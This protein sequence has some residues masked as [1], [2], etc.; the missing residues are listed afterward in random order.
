MKTLSKLGLAFC[1]C[2]LSLPALAQFD[3]SFVFDDSMFDDSSLFETADSQ[4]GHF[5]FRLSHQS[6]AHINRHTRAAVGGGTETRAR[7]LEN[8]RSALNI[9][10]QNPFREGWLLQASG[11]LRGY[12]PGDYE[13][14]NPT[15]EDWEWRLNE[16]FVQRSG[17]RNSLA[18]GRQ[19]IVW[20]E[21]IGNSVLDVINTTEYRDLTIIDIEDARLNQWLLVW[22]HFSDHGTWSS[23][24]NLY[25]E[26]DPLPVDNSPLFPGSPLRLPHYHRDKPLFELGTRWSRSFTGSDV[27]VMAARLYENGLRFTPP[28]DGSN[29]AI[30]HIN[31]Y[32]LLGL[33]ANRAIDR[34]L[35]TLDMSYSQGVLVDSLTNAFP[36]LNKGDLLGISAGFEYGISATRLISVG[37]RFE[38]LQNIERGAAERIN[39]LRL[40]TRGD[41]LVRYSHSIMNEEVM[42]SATFQ[43]QLDGEAGLLNLAADYRINDDWELRSQI[44]LTRADPAST[45]YFLDQDIRLGLT[46]SYSF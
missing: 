26:F 7:G 2:S 32:M 40:D 14:N 34:L 1:A 43:G 27:A 8:N 41:L 30:A 15:R 35:L 29:R 38:R 17:Q 3:D 11:Q 44:I 31:D 23:F 46:L 18:F 5:R 9:R 13:Y 22:D 19:T 36:T 10:Y 45:L 24:V 25:P 28:T 12:L 20:G 4:P 21:T 39:D 33:S 37:L 6:V 42:L 16:L